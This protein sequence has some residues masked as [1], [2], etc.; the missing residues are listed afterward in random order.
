M[1]FWLGSLVWLQRER[2]CLALQRLDLPELRDIQGEPHPLRG[3]G[4]RNGR[5]TVG[6]SV[7]ERGQCIGCKMDE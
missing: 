1:F 2:M 3:D 6:G 7:R 4:E 5:R